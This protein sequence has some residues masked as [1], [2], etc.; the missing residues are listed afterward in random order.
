MGKFFKNGCRRCLAICL[1]MGVMLTSSVSANA[2]VYGGDTYN[3]E[4]FD[5]A[6]YDIYNEN[7]EY[8]T[9]INGEKRRFIN[10]WEGEVITDSELINELNTFS[11]RAIS[12]PYPSGWKNNRDVSL[13]YGQTYTERVNLA[14]SQYYSPGFVVNVPNNHLVVGAIT[15]D[16]LNIGLFETKT[17]NTVVYFRLA[18]TGMWSAAE[19]RDFDYNLAIPTQDLKSGKLSSHID[20]VC[21]KM[22]DVTSNYSTITGPYPKTFT[23]T[24]A[25]T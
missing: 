9:I 16:F 1:A 20:K 19:V 2:I 18:D 22:V 15:V 6:G 10:P 8:F 23:Y 12:E 25:Q 4:T 5:V 11:T 21:I 3:D 17:I 14:V 24:I 13:L 7:G